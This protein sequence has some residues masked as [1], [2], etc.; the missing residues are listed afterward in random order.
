MFLPSVI[1]EYVA[2]DI[3]NADE[4]VL[5]FKIMPDKLFVLK[6]KKCHDRKLSIDRI[7]VPLATNADS[8][9]KQPPLVLGNLAKPR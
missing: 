1:A 7:T 6:E 8:F 5:F 3:F 9:E 4:C 2:R